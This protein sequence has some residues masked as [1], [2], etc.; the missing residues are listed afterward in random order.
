MKKT[1]IFMV[2]LISVA[3]IGNAFAVSPGKSVP[4]DSKMGKVTFDGKTHADAGLKCADCHPK[5]FQMKKGTF[6]MDVPHKA[7]ANCGACHDGTKAFSQM[8]AA[9]CKKCHKKEAG[10][11]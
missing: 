7:G 8:D 1:V 9:N 10:G 11:Y 3:L 4:Y 6:K 2:L 5:M